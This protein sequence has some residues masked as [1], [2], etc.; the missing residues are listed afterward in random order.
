M[1]YQV[2]IDKALNV[3]FDRHEGEITYQ[4]FRD[5]IRELYEHP[6]WQKGLD[7]ISDL[8]EASLVLSSSEMRQIITSF[9]V[10]DEANK[11]AV[12][13]SRDSEFGMARMFEILSEET[14]IWKEYKIFRDMAEAKKWL[15]IGN[16]TNPE[17]KW[18]T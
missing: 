11:L 15:G 5:S 2:Y 7:V 12:V 1:K 8:R 16:Y 10:D 4:A 6:D 14:N 9:M 13:V 3:L 17:I 18:L